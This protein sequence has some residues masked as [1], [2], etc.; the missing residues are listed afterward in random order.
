MDTFAYQPSGALT[1]AA[2]AILQQHARGNRNHLI[3]GR[4]TGT[5]FAFVAS[6][7]MHRPAAHIFVGMGQIG[8]QCWYGC[9]VDKVIE[10]FAA[11]QQ[12]R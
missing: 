1:Q 5:F 8:D 9:F 2:A 3:F 4:S 6:Q 12:S 7:G 11:T 10:H